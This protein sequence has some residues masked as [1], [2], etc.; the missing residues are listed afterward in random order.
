LL[1]GAVLLPIIYYGIQPTLAPFHPGYDFTTDVVSLLGASG[2]PVAAL[3]NTGVILS[4]LAALAGAAGFWRAMRDTFLGLRLLLALTILGIG[5]GNIWA[6]LFPLPDARHGA[7]PLLPAFLVTPF[8]LCLG[9]WFSPELKPLRLFLSLNLI[10]FAVFALTT[11]GL[12]GLDRTAYAGWLQ[13]FGAFTIMGAIGISG[14][15]L[16]RREARLPVQKPPRTSRR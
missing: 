7:N 12:I 14:W 6:G 15:F 9:G 10:L 8:L 3:F 2:A 13:R 11:A 1:W 16:L 5:V 4:G